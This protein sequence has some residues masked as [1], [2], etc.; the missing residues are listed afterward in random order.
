MASLDAGPSRA[1]AALAPQADDGSI[2]VSDSESGSSYIGS[3]ATEPYSPVCRW[4]TAE[5]YDQECARFFDCP[6]HVVERVLSDQDAERPEGV[7]GAA[8]EEQEQVGGEEEVRPEGH[9]DDAVDEG[10]SDEER[11]GERSEEGSSE[12]IGE[13]SS[14]VTSEAQATTETPVQEDLSSEGATLGTLGMFEMPARQRPAHVLVSRPERSSSLFVR[15]A[16]SVLQSE[17]TTARP[18]PGFSDL[19]PSPG[20]QQ[21]VP[22]AGSS[23]SSPAH[24]PSRGAAE[25]RALPDFVLPRWQPDAEVTYCP[26]CHTQFSIFVRKHHCR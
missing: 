26:I 7:D 6:S 16:P 1:A 9:D 13:V 22:A 11:T 12:D 8:G 20:P 14:R 5:Y 23:S 17:S 24:P 4:R 15:P 3:D 18:S 21:T 2:D 25:S 19:R 10:R